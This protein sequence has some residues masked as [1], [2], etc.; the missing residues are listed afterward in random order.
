MKTEQKSTILNR[1]TTLP[2]LLD[3]LRRK[4]MVLHNPQNWED[5]NDTETMLAYKKKRAVSSLLAICFC[6]GH[7]TVHHWKAYANGICG[8]CIEF[9]KAKLE[10]ALIGKKGFQGQDVEYVTINNFKNGI[11]KKELPFIKRKPFYSEKEFRIVWEGEPN[12]ETIDMDINLN[13]IN[14]ITLSYW[15][16]DELFKST[17]ELLGKIIGKQPIEINQDWIIEIDGSTKIV[18]N[19]STIFENPEWIEAAR[20]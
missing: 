7:E 11:Y 19:H 2:E 8:C 14:K 9:D 5:K 4:K 1:F 13:T 20:K 12:K 16:P 18:I 6:I 17:V 15:M 3:L 10:S